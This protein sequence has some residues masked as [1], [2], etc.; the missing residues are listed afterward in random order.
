MA[1]KYRSRTEIVAAILNASFDP[2]NKAK[3]MFKTYL[4][5]ALLNEYLDVMMKND[6]LQCK[7]SG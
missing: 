1:F 6:L 3:I 4:S 5:Y 2:T 7:E